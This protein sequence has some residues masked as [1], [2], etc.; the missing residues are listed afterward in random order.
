MSSNPP[1]NYT[2]QTSDNV[3]VSVRHLPTR[4]PPLPPPA[5]VLPPVEHKSVQEDL[6]PGRQQIIIGLGTGRCGTHSLAQLLNRQPNTNVTHEINNRPFLPWDRDLRKL[7]Q[8]FN[9]IDAKL[10][11]F[12]TVGDVAFYHLPY[13]DKLIEQYPTKVKFIAIKRD[14][15]AVIKS[16]LKWSHELNFWMKHDGTKWPYSEWDICYPKYD[17]EKK[18]EALQLYLDEYKHTVDRYRQEYPGRF[19]L[20]EVEHL[21]NKNNISD[22]LN[23]CGYNNK[24]IIVGIRRSPTR[25]PLLRK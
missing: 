6:D 25:K 21:N 2:I 14:S 15:T 23:F 20:M 7:K 10:K 17:V 8:F 12:N 9:I 22:L 18:I 24:N 16:Y 13:V 5:D 3:D 11:I 19:F 4:N 1:P